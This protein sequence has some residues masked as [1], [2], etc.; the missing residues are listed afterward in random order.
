[1]SIRVSQECHDA[2][3][4]FGHGMRGQRPAFVLFKINPVGGVVLDKIGEPTDNYNDFVEQLPLDDA[5]W[6]CLTV[7]YTTHGGGDRSK[8]IFVAWIPGAS[9]AVNKMQYAAFQG[10]F[11]H[12]INA[13]RAHLAAHGLDDL[14]PEELL[15]HASKFEVDQV[16]HEKGLL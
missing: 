1:M 14:T 7:N 6:G 4:A 3:H 9:S 15:A 11:R 5:R 16:D 12:A 2:M 13:P 8:A 10:G